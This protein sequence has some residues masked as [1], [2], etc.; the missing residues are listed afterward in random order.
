MKANKQWRREVK[1]FMHR[2]G[3]KTMAQAEE[4]MAGPI[5]LW[6]G[7]KKLDVHG[8][9]Y[10]ADWL[11][12]RRK[13]NELAPVINKHLAEQSKRRLGLIHQTIR[14]MATKPYLRSRDGYTKAYHVATDIEDLDA[15]RQWL[16]GAAEVIDQHYGNG[17]FGLR[18]EWGFVQRDGEE[19]K[20]IHFRGNIYRAMNVL[21]RLAVTNQTLTRKPQLL[22]DEE[23]ALRA[24]VVKKA[25]RAVELSRPPGYPPERSDPF[26]ADPRLNYRPDAPPDMGL[27]SYGPEDWKLMSDF[28]FMIQ[29]PEKGLE[30]QAKAY[31]GWWNKIGRKRVAAQ[32]IRSRIAPFS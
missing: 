5:E 10:V 19:V 32:N 28:L 12:D 21:G 22:S 15:M 26:A 4:V 14:W 13:R 2:F 7:L 8:R 29:V 17:H 6:R 3:L 27:E 24:T 1:L 9:R 16:N 20:A 25:S 23:R 31:D 30:H 11:I 18:P